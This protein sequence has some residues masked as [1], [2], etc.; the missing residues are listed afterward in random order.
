MH[1]FLHD[2][3][4]DVGMH[5]SPQLL[6]GLLFLCGSKLCLIHIVLAHV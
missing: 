4:P 3:C 2:S 1:T 6:I 5:F